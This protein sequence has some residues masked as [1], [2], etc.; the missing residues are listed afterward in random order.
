MEHY[1]THPDTELLQ[2]LAGDDQRAFE[3]LYRRYHSKLFFF[4]QKL[5]G[6]AAT[7]E[8]V[9]QDVFIKLWT[10][11]QSL[12]GVDNLNAWIFRIT[13]NQVINL[14]KRHANET[15]ILREIAHDVAPGES[16]S[17]ELLVQKNIHAV[18][19]QV[20]DELPA[21][22]KLVFTLSREE[23]LT[24]AQIGEKLGISALTAKKH[25][26]QALRTLRKKITGDYLPM[27]VLLFLR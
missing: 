14:L 17:H 10:T 18:L 11:R 16:I 15:L 5:S 19:R 7:A 6:S 20:V 1:T 4:I 13:R 9:L 27:F 26:A 25:A 22:Q 3:E 12:S 23:G 2:L 8:D 24:Y 21:Q